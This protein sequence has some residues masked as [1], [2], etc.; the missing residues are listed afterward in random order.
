MIQASPQAVD[1]DAEVLPSEESVVPPGQIGAGSSGSPTDLP[2]IVGSVPTAQDFET[3]FSLR[4]LRATCTSIRKEIRLLR[5]RDAVDWLDWF[6]TLDASLEQLREQ[7]LEGD[8]TPTPPSRYEMGKS[9]GAFRII[10]SF[11]ICDALVYR[12]ISDAAL[13]AALPRKVQGAFFSR[14]H[15]ATPV[16]KTFSVSE[17]DEYLNFF[18][19]WLRYNE[20]RTH[21][22][23]QQPYECLVVTDITNYFESIQHDLLIEYLAP[24]GLPRK[25]MGLLGRLLEAFKPLAGHSPNPRVGLPVDELDCS[26][27][28]AHVFLFEHDRRIVEPFGEDNYVRWMDD[29][30]IGVRSETEARH[31][32]N[33]MTRSLSSQ[34][35]TLNSGKTKF[36]PVDCMVVH[37]Q[38]DANKKISEWD[39]KYK[40]VTASNVEA[41]RSD[42]AGLWDEVG[43]G[44][45]VNDGNW[46]KILKRMY[47]LAVKVDSDILEVRALGDL[48]ANPELDERIFTYF[49][50][51]NRFAE[52]FS[53]FSSYTEAEESL[54]EATEVAFFESSLLLDPDV[55]HAKLYRNQALRFAEGG[56]K[57]RS[58]RP[59]SI[60]SAI[61]S[62]YWFDG[63]IDSLVDLYPTKAA[64]RLPKEVART[65]MACVAALS[66]DQ[67]GKVQSALFGHPSD[68]VARLGRFLTE[69]LAGRVH[70]L[71]HYK[72]QKHRWPLPGDYYD[73]R[74]WLILDIAAS[75]P[76]E[77]LRAQNRKDYGA[78]EKLAR[79]SPEITVSTRISTKLFEGRGEEPGQ[80]PRRTRQGHKKKGRHE[81]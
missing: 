65:W 77:R 58:K 5:A 71:G 34:R 6:L 1:D 75:S 20:Y 15:S 26:R 8:Y 16:G 72:S 50:K 29:Q 57:S 10:T 11:N 17:D 55:P 78:F 40:K 24:L 30:N 46:D 66:P 54:F 28:L 22:L 73:A 33:T 62:V 35:L 74:S 59:L 47:G 2:A 64:H 42:F 3:L 48:I 61:L 68:D 38:L 19:V 32:V 52:L 31:V 4:K 41:A 23:L 79:T 69:L 76:S 81:A 53:L 63:S 27:Q 14:R 12:H 49:S 37:F 39:E 21:T 25:A 67:L 44:P 7:I 36:L 51:R 60:A 43:D 70:H 13:E 18:E 56:V 80:K 9:K 45:H